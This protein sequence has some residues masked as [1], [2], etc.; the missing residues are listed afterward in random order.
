VTPS[1]RGVAVAKRLAVSAVVALVVVGAV[2]LP[3]LTDTTAEREPTE[4]AAYDAEALAATPIPA[5]GDIEPDTPP[6]AQGGTVVVDATH[7]N[8]FSRSD[9]EPLVEE[10]AALGY[11]VR[12]HDGGRNLYDALVG[13]SAFVVIDPADSFARNEVTTV[14]TFTRNG[15]HLLL[16]GEPTRKA[17]SGGFGGVSVSSQESALTT[18]AARYDMALGT[19]YLT[20]TETNGGNHKHVVAEPT[21]ASDVDGDRVVL[22]TAAAVHSRGG[23]VL[24]RA[25]DG[26]REAG[27]DSSGRYPVAVLK[28]RENAVLVGDSSV[29]RADR[30]TVA[31]NEAF[32]AFLVDFLV[33][34]E[35]L[36]DGTVDG[37]E[38]GSDAAVDE[39]T[40]TA[41][42]AT[43]S[44]SPSPATA[45]G[46]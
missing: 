40:R 25:A 18:L 10:L 23:T 29:L 27:T 2:T 4:A 33:G 8:R 13:A 37:P 11:D 30:V 35:P 31:D 3:A 46:S 19:R 24:L 21:A 34:G 39:S 36:T 12:I 44:P 32:A 5:V 45:P 9:I 6:E 43:P 26:T 16:V 7:S 28:T 17:V 15:G 22:F 41:E 14:R 1:E 42:P 20:N 38:T